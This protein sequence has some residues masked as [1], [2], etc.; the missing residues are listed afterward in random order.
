MSVTSLYPAQVVLCKLLQMFRD[1]NGHAVADFEI[2]LRPEDFCPA[3]FLPDALLL[4]S[5]ALLPQSSETVH[6]QALLTF[7]S[8]ELCGFLAEAESTTATTAHGH[9]DVLS[10]TTR[11]LSLSL[12]EELSIED[13]RRLT[14]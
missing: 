1:E 6:S 5:Q 10:K 4:E 8:P 9:F 3:R 14:G 7:R 13:E 11:T 12:E 2:T